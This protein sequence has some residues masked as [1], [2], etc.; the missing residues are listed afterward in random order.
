MQRA[1]DRDNQH[2]Q[3]G[4]TL[5]E[6]L[7]AMAMTGLLVVAMY[8]LF[9]TMQRNTYKEDDVV[10]IQQ[11]LR[12]AFDLLSQDIEM[13]GALIA[14]EPVA[15]TSD[16]ATLTLL[17]ASPLYTYGVLSSDTSVPTTTSAGDDVTFKLRV[18]EMVDGFNNG[19]MVRLI[20]PMDSGQPYDGD[21]IVAGKNRTN[22][23]L[24]VNGFSPANEINY[25]IGD[26]FVRVSCPKG[27]TCPPTTSVFPG[28]IS[29]TVANGV[30]ERRIV[31]D[32]A[33][34]S[35]DDVQT[36]LGVDPAGPDS[37]QIT[38]TYLDDDGDDVTAAVGTNP[39]DVQ[40]V[41]A[42]LTMSRQVLAGS[43]GTSQV[44]RSLAGTFKLRNAP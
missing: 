22:Q 40:A 23:T 19:Q 4:F 26:I 43:G 24:A 8:A 20:R 33:N 1:K 21:L 27:A 42:R 2:T 44:T 15:D 11:E 32:P 3:R 17:T 16:A 35:D 39:E 34:P 30:L 25:Q 7:V 6:L 18:P 38:F 13:A 28:R 37:L 14:E 10:A 31:H 41:Q 5:A 12:A 9:N 36:V 29:W